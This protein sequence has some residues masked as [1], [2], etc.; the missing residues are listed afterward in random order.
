MSDSELTSGYRVLEEIGIGGQGEVFLAECVRPTET[1]VRPGEQVAL[2][3][4]FYRGDTEGDFTSFLSR[5]ARLRELKH[6]NIVEYRD[7]FIW[8]GEHNRKCLVMERLTGQTL[9]AM[10]KAQPNG[11]LPWETV[12]PV[13]MSCI[14]ALVF[15]RDKGISPHRDMKPSNIF[16]ATDGAVKV[17]DFDVAHQGQKESENKPTTVLVTPEYLPPEMYDQDERSDIYSMGV[18]AFECLTGRRPQDVAQK[19]GKNWGEDAEIV[20]LVFDQ[21]AFWLLSQDVR[22]CIKRSIHPDRTKRFQRLE[23][24]RE[25]LSKGTHRTIRGKSDD[26]GKFD[27]YRLTEFIARGGFGMVFKAERISDGMTVCVKRLFKR[28]YT[29][30]FEREARVLKACRHQHIVGYVDVGEPGPD[31]DLYLVMEFLSGMPGASLRK[32]LDASPGGLDSTEVLTTFRNLASA[33]SYLHTPGNE[34]RPAIIHRDIKPE[35]LYTPEGHPER[36]KVLD[37]G[38]ARDME[39]ASATRDV[40][41]TFNYMAPEFAAGRSGSERGS[42]RTDVYS[43]GVCLYEALTGDMP[44]GRLS[45]KQDDALREFS[46]RVKHRNRQVPNLDRAPFTTHPELREVVGRS[47]A[48]NPSERYQ[49]ANEMLL[50]LLKAT[51]GIAKQ[52]HVPEP[53]DANDTHCATV[54]MAA[55]HGSAAPGDDAT[56]TAGAATVGDISRAIREQEE[57]VKADRRRRLLRDAGRWVSIAAASVPVMWL[58]VFS[59]Q[60]FAASAKSLDSKQPA[61]HPVA[62]QLTRRTLP[63]P[64]VG[65][66]GVPTNQATEHAQRTVRPAVSGGVE[67]PVVEAPV[68]PTPPPRSYAA[69][70]SNAS[71]RVSAMRVQFSPTPL[72]LGRLADERG[73]LVSMAAS[74]P[75]EAYWQANVFGPLDELR[76][77]AVRGLASGKVAGLQRFKPEAKYFAELSEWRTKLRSLAAN[78]DPDGAEWWGGNVY[79]P[80]TNLCREAPLRFMSSVYEW[81]ASGTNLDEVAYMAEEWERARTNRESLGVADLIDLPD[82]VRVAGLLAKRLP[83]RLGRGELADRESDALDYEELARTTVGEHSKVRAA[84]MAGRSRLAAAGEAYIEKLENDAVAAYER[85]IANA[86]PEQELRQFERVAPRLAGL[87]KARLNGAIKAVDAARA[88]HHKRVGEVRTAIDDL[89]QHIAAVSAFSAVSEPA[90]GPIPAAVDAVSAYWKRRD[91]PTNVLDRADSLGQI[92]CERLREVVVSEGQLAGRKQ[93]LDNV[94][95]MVAKAGTEGLPGAWDVVGRLLSNQNAVFIVAIG[96]PTEYD[97]TFEAG[98]TEQAVKVPSGKSALARLRGRKQGEA[99]RAQFKYGPAHEDRPLLL[100]FDGGGAANVTV[101]PTVKRAFSVPVVWPSGPLNPPPSVRLRDDA[102]AWTTVPNRAD[103]VDLTAGEFVAEFTRNG[104]KP[105]TAGLVVQCGETQS[106]LVVPGRDKWE[107]IEL[108]LPPLTAD[109][110]KAVTAILR[111]MYQIRDPE[112]NLPRSGSERWPPQD[113]VEILRR[114]PQNPDFPRLSAWS[115]GL[116]SVA[117]PAGRQKLAGRLERVAAQLR[118]AGNEEEARKCIFDAAILRDPFPTLQVREFALFDEGQ[119]WAAHGRYPNMEGSK[120]DLLVGLAN[121]FKQQ[122]ERPD[123]YDLQLAVYLAWQLWEVPANPGPKGLSDSTVYR[124]TR[125]A[126]MLEGLLRNAAPETEDAVLAFLAGKARDRRSVAGRPSDNAALFQIKVLTILP[127]LP[128]ERGIRAKAT[129]WLRDNEHLWNAES[130]TLQSQYGTLERTILR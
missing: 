19:M 67:L 110:E 95:G 121:F 103:K 6:G 3:R 13:M 77:N 32:R 119:K 63:A 107:P 105:I 72:Y 15:A 71:E 49:T 122:K 111:W 70:R 60:R 81:L 51:R 64:M 82:A 8:G 27:S 68:L 83:D 125:V 25:A 109:A 43:L 21:Q 47:V 106:A 128:A 40:P 123:V 126:V 23:E 117:T 89:D 59:V 1:G 115:D 102:G 94:A 12:Q 2:K 84:L 100:V 30:Y 120:F 16:I 46:D 54:L 69:V 24:M 17:L 26:R 38:V 11:T 80:I 45:R 90:C 28:Q 114:M 29:K 118:T 55:E 129:A 18:C 104:F 127:G 87:T 48:F 44:Y 74:D 53:A 57:R 61:R 93:R 41:G 108:P 92:V 78:N 112:M 75:D 116:D 96:N 56:H 91:M 65:V 34:P 36:C 76:V 42:P 4:M 66:T 31:G 10:L 35:N 39:S 62:T 20:D 33:L 7:A 37:L 58:L 50:G 14:D 101:P 98:G 79:G 113:S 85:G 99:L 52:S 5:A 97:A 86:A 22:E 73:N 88:R 124:V 9:Q 130:V